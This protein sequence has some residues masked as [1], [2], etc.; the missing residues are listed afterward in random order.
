MGDHNPAV[1]AYIQNA[2]EFARPVLVHLRELVH[3]TAPG[4]QETIKWRIP[5]FEYKGI[6]C[7]MAAFKQHCSFGFWKAS[8]LKDKNLFE[9]T[10]SGMGNLGKIRKLDDL[11]PD[12]LL[13]ACIRDAVHLNENDIRVSAAKKKK[14]TLE[15]PKDFAAELKTNRAANT[16]FSEFAPG[17]QRDYIEW[18]TGAKT[19]KTRQKRLATA[20]EWIGEGKHRNWKYEGKCR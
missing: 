6:V 9:T 2:A 20:I 13:I 14:K 8:L 11:P 1:D 5:C 19:E 18:I 7:N 10:D 3:R 16:H 15:I 17:Y 4:I 12:E